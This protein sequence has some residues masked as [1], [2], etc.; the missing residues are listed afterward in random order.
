[1]STDPELTAA[2]Q[3]WV[4]NVD[5]HIDQITKLKE[6][7]A[8]YKVGDI[9]I[10][11]YNDGHIDLNSLGESP[12][13]KVVAVS[14]HGVPF[15]KR[16]SSRGGL[17]GP[18]TIIHTA[19]SLQFLTYGTYNNTSWKFVPDPDQLDAIMLE[20]EYDPMKNHNEKLQLQREILDHNK[21]ASVNTKY[22]GDYIDFLKGLKVGDKIW[23][24]VDKQFVVHTAA[25]VRGK[26]GWSM[27]LIDMDQKEVV[28]PLKSFSYKRLYRTQPRSF[29]KEV[30][31]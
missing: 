11:E 8:A 12:K 25:A 18:A 3:Q 15:L 13:Y 16:M 5:A 21:L 26:L 7:G 20:E 19:S 2:E 14:K 29:A 6:S 30:K 17:T 22:D 1:M 4:A 27:T 9:Y 28:V 31:K 24:S 10:I 23:T